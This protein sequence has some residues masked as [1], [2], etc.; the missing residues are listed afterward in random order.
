MPLTASIV[1]VNVNGDIQAAI[2]ALGS[3][4]GIVQLGPG[5]YPIT[6]T[7]QISTPITLRGSGPNSTFL[8]AYGLGAS[9]DVIRISSSGDLRS[10]ELKDFQIIGTGT[11]GRYG[12]YIDTLVS[13]AT[14]AYCNFENLWVQG[15]GT[16]AFFSEQHLTNPD[17]FFNST[18][19]RCVLGGCVTLLRAGDSLTFRDNLFSRQGGG[20][21]VTLVD[22]AGRFEVSGNVF[23]SNPG[24][25][26]RNS[27]IFAKIE[28]NFFEPAAG[29]TNPNADGAS[30]S[31]LGD[32]ASIASTLVL[33]NQFNTTPGT[34]G[35]AIYVGAASGTVV[36]GN[37]VLYGLATHKGLV[38]ASSASYTTIGN[39][40]FWGATYVDVVNS[41]RVQDAST[42]SIYPLSMNSP[43]ATLSAKTTD[44][45]VSYEDDYVMYDDT[46]VTY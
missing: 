43:N 7:L 10:V 3:A 8:T 11:S 33:N 15:L 5:T 45:F 6:A 21:D 38:V 31:V 9:T 30:V 4:G 46:I 1:E 25:I 39:N 34:G 26:L 19:S 23:I 14:V 35:T 17:G 42:T 29:T 22:G 20:L 16:G 27:T 2:D 18:I 44:D 24:I 32:V 40:Q 41:V 28:G 37:K 12:V 13:A 36:D